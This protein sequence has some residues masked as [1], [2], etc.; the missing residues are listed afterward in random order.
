VPAGHPFSP[1]SPAVRIKLF[2]SV[3][4]ILT[5][6]VVDLTLTA[7]T[8]CI[9]TSTDQGA[10]RQ[11]A[12]IALIGPKGSDIVDQQHISRI[13]ADDQFVDFDG[14]VIVLRAMGFE[15][16]NDRKVR[17]AAD[18]GRLPF[19]AYGKKRRILVRVLKDCFLRMQNEAIRGTTR[20]RHR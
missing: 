19:F 8:E 7:T 18:E 15:D 5:S 13:P 16:Q 17:R 1:H 2:L 9:V 20:L 10:S 11:I 4:S 12:H 3:Q 6:L 14:A